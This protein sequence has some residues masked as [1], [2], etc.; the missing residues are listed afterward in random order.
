MSSFLPR[1]IQLL[2]LLN[3]RAE[4]KA[5]TSYTEETDKPLVASGL[6]WTPSTLEGEVFVVFGTDTP[7]LDMGLSL[8]PEVLQP[9]PL[10]EGLGT[11]DL[12]T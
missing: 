5:E 8:L 1:L 7:T 6:R 4:T 11:A 10:S 3:I 9:A 12:L 2:L